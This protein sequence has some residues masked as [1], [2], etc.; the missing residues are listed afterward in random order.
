MYPDAN[1][2]LQLGRERAGA[3]LREVHRDRLR[4]LGSVDGASH[5]RPLLLRLR[6]AER[7]AHPA[8]ADAK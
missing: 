4:Q 7:R 6:P 8:Q 3:V 5:R 1:M 2:R